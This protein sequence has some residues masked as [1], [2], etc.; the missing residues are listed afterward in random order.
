VQQ[1]AEVE[2]K[3]WKNEFV[4]YLKSNQKLKVVSDKN[5]IL[6]FLILY[7][8]ELKNELNEIS[9]GAVEHSATKFEGKFYAEL[10]GYRSAQIEYYNM[11]NG[12]VLKSVTRNTMNNSTTKVEKMAFLYVD[13]NMPFIKTSFD[14]YG[15][16]IGDAEIFKV[17]ILDEIVE[18]Y[19]MNVIQN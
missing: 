6:K 17:K 2:T 18:A 11:K 10:N 16:P 12:I 15:E 19:F 5:D 7:F 14:V 9:E 4:D 13:D 1:Q 3:N 8:E